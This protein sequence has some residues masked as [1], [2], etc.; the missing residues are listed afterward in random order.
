MSL[1]HAHSLE[2]YLEVRLEQILAAPDWSGIVAVQSDRYR[3][4]V[5]PVM[6]AACLPRLEG[7][8]RLLTTGQ[9]VILSIRAD[10]ASSGSGCD[11]WPCPTWHRVNRLSYYS[12]LTPQPGRL[13][14]ILGQLLG[15]DWTQIYS[16][17]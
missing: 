3:L 4:E 13:L 1:I 14:I 7:F 8:S 11:R 2:S 9:L 17:L 5:D 12:A 6:A 15:Q 10:A 16:Y